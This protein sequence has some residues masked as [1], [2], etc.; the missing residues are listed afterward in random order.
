MKMCNCAHSFP[1]SKIFT[2]MKLPLRN[3]IVNWKEF[4]CCC[5]YLPPNDWITD[6][7]TNLIK[8][9]SKNEILDW[10]EVMD[11]WFSHPHFI[12]QSSSTAVAHRHKPS[13]FLSL[14]HFSSFSFGFVSSHRC[15]RRRH[16][17]G[18]M[19]VNE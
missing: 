2:M 7:N 1:R 14:I 18:E 19:N 17:Y 16:R 9:L 8:V 10:E 5:Y 12:L 11:A 13:H 3:S 4:C 15:R 6:L